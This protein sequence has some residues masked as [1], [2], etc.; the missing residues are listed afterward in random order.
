[1]QEELLSMDQ[2]M[3]VLDNA[4]V[5]IYVNEIDN[6]KLIYANHLAKEFFLQQLNG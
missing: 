1:M 2:M 5:A 6:W 3:A 4:P